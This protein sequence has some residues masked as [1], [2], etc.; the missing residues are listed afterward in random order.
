MLEARGNKPREFRLAQTHLHGVFVFSTQCG[1]KHGGVI[2]GE[3]HRNSVPEQFWKRMIRDSCVGAAKLLREGP[4][5]D[6]A[7][8]TDFERYAAF[9]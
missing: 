1:V 2:S 3:Q 8:W 5:A 9:R 4:G 7:L 6:V